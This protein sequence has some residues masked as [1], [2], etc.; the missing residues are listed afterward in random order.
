MIALRV[1]RIN[2]QWEHYWDDLYKKV[3]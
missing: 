1:M 3:A 2:G